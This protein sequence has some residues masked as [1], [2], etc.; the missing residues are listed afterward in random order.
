VV[1]A[2]RVFKADVI[3][4][5]G[6]IAQIGENLN[7][8][9]AR[10]L[11]AT[12]RY[13]MPGG[14]DPHVHFE[15]PF[16]GTVS[17]DDFYHGTQAAVAGGTTMILDFAI[18][19]RRDM[20][21][22]EIF[23]NYKK[24]G[25]DKAVCDFGLHVGIVNV[26]YDGDRDRIV[27]EMAELVKRGVNSF[28]FFMAYKGVFQLNDYE[29]FRGF[30][31]ARELGAISMVHAENGD[32]VVAGQR[33]VLEQGIHGPEGHS[34]SRPPEVE[35]EATRRVATIAH[36]AHAPLY[37]VHVMSK[38]AMLEVARAKLEGYR[39]IGETVAAALSLNETALFDKE[40]DRAA[41]YVMSPPIRSINDQQALV[42]AVKNK[43]LD[44][45]GTDHCT[46][47]MAQKRMGVDDFTKIP[48]GVNGVEERMMVLYDR[49]V[50]SGKI[51]VS[52]YV[53]ITSTEAAQLFNIYPQKGVIAVGSDADI[54]LFDPTARRVINHKTQHSQIDYNVYDDWSFWGAVET[55][56]S[57]GRVVWHNGTLYTTK[58]SGRFVPTPPFGKMFHG[59]ES[60]IY[61][62]EEFFAGDGKTKKG[63]N[64]KGSW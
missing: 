59:L 11:N 24:L 29:L 57:S 49:L 38:A 8:S 27:K 46:F 5:N 16:M 33:R 13:V 31:I 12:G 32:L 44:L 53:R 17:K 37:V 15:L 22:V 35:A 63:V 21:H 55:T 23:E 42:N 39:I 43:I 40:W 54:I 56:I 51:T 7:D 58:G 2:D 26:D 41:R 10:F 62:S 20:S 19:P 50:H 61:H 34:F 28:K 25:E 45:V 1:N 60:E 6:K 64:R 52:D 3:V 48:N 30:S 47:D 18:P 14:I 36:Q 9:N 4:R